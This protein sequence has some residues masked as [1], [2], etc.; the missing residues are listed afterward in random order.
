[1][2]ACDGGRGRRGSDRLT[3]VQLLQGV[4]QQH[5]CKRRHEKRCLKGM[6]WES[7]AESAGGWGSCGAPVKMVD[8]HMGEGAVLPIDAPHNLVHHAA[9]QSRAAGEQ[10]WVQASVQ[11]G[12]SA[13]PSTAGQG[14]RV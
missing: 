13:V 7:K 8:G 6:Q 1:M 9:E 11:R 14:V 5:E 12:Q 3:Q 4:Q 10:Q 2:G